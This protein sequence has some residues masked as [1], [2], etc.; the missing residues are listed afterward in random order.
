MLN[1]FNTSM[2]YVQSASKNRARYKETQPT[3]FTSW[4]A[5]CFHATSLKFGCP[6]APRGALTARLNSGA[7]CPSGWTE[8]KTA[9]GVAQR[10]AT[11]PQKTG[12][13]FHGVGGR[14]DCEWRLQAHR[15]LNG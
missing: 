1:S 4:M 13:L 12:I 8:L 11:Y 3:D 15:S 10:G 14:G 6:W 5:F 9:F 7:L 2:L